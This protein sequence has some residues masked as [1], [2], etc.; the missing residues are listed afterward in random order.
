VNA[1]RERMHEADLRER[2]R[3][4]KTPLRTVVSENLE[5]WLACR[6]AAERPV[7]G[8]V[9]DELRGYLA[10]GIPCFGFARAVCMTC[11]T[12]LAVAFSGEGRGVCPS[13]A[14]A[15]LTKVFLTAI[16]RLPSTQRRPTGS[17]RT[18]AVIHAT[19]GQWRR[20]TRAVC[21][22]RPAGCSRPAAAG[23]CTALW[24]T[25]S[26]RPKPSVSS[27]TSHSSAG[28]PL[29]KCHWPGY[30]FPLQPRCHR[31]NLFSRVRKL[32]A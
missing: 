7:P 16:E 9:E 1:T 19:V 14:V 3:P 21:V 4:E 5:N 24:G 20:R 18:Q 28:R 26:G 15:S 6:E 32:R 25:A 2:R 11:R 17:A 23:G 31:P 22:P 27:R 30:P 29:T 13:R 8:Y 10:F 12:G